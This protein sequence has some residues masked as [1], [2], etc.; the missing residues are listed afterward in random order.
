MCE[1]LGELHRGDNWL[2]SHKPAVAQR[3]LE[4]FSFGLLMSDHKQSRA[5]KT[6]GWVVM[7]GG[8]SVYLPGLMSRVPC[9]IE[10]KC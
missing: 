2:A 1:Q 5:V 9:R 6:Q 4:E 3:E 7:G 10:A 8:G